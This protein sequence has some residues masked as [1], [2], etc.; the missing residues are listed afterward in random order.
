MPSAMEPAQR[1]DTRRS[2]RD[3]SAHPNHRL[4]AAGDDRENGRESGD[5][6][7]L[8]DMRLQREERDASLERLEPLRR[9]DQRAQADAA[10]V[11]ELRE[12]EKQPPRPLVDTL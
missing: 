3:R 8:L 10:D 12:I 5:V 9:D 11:V 7:D 4:V 6:E 1:R 2:G